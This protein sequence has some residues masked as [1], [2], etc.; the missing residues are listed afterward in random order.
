VK[1]LVI[2]QPAE[3]RRDPTALQDLLD[4]EIV[5]GHEELRNK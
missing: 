4:E 2:G 3:E 1:L 5:V